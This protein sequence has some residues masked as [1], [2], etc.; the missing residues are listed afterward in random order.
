RHRAMPRHEIPPRTDAR[1]PP[2]PSTHRP[3]RQRHRHQPRRRAGRLR[4][5]RQRRLQEIRHR[6]PRA[7]HSLNPPTTRESGWRIDLITTTSTADIESL[8]NGRAVGY[9]LE[10]P[11]YVN[12]EVYELDLEAIFAKHWLFVATEAEFPEPGDF[13]TVDVGPYS[14]IIVRDDDEN[15]RALFNVCRHRGSRILDA[16]RGAVGNLVCPYHQWT[17][18]T[19]GSLIFAESQPPTFDKKHFGLKSVH[20]RTVAG[21]VFVCLATEAPSDFDE[22]VVA[23]EPYLTPYGLAN[24]KVA[25]QVDLVE[26]GNWKLMMENNH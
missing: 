11:L 16:P 18:R 14:V 21:L 5:I 25:H 24:T 17:Y 9:S 7:H 13:V 12:R 2:R 3:S 23:I 26:N 6:P 15:V 10:A 19:D 8:V 20:V 4:R 1:H 22:V